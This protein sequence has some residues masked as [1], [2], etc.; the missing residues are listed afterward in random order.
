VRR[1]SFAQAAAGEGAAA[2]NRVF[3]RYLVPINFSSEQLH[4]HITY[5][6]VDAGASPIWYDDAGTVLAAALLAIRGKRGWIG[7]F[8]VAPEYRGRGY[9]SELLKTLEDTARE[10]GLESIQMEVLADNVP[11]IQAYR[12]AGYEIVRT[13]HSFERTFENA[14]KPSGFVN[15]SPEEFIAAPDPV[16][17]C[18]QRER[19]TLRN[20]AVSTAITDARDSYAL[21]RYNA[22]AAQVLKLNVP[23]AASLDALAQ[24]IASGREFQSI[25]ILNE[26][27]NS[28]IST[29]AKTAHWNEPFTQYEMGLSL[30]KR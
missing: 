23:S 15:A 24:A 29:Y 30:S 20:G 10:R 18:W 14:E 16:T 4:L 11:A 25:L 21:Y 19:A 2:L 8:G 9:A 5:N 26:P 7:G 22:Q 3:E 6:D 27:A 17:P 12:K 28:P 1:A 13:L